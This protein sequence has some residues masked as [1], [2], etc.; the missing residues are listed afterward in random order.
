MRPS[1][2]YKIIKVSKGERENLGPQEVLDFPKWL[3]LYL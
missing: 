1:H 3:F 2:K